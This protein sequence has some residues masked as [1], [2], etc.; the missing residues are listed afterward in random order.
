MVDAA[1]RRAGR[2]RPVHHAFRGVVVFQRPQHN[3]YVVLF[4]EFMPR[5]L[6]G[7]ELV[8]D[9]STVDKHGLGVLLT[10]VPQFNLKEPDRF[11][12]I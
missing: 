7:N 6:T 12:F 5:L 9:F 1:A 3:I 11:I 2:E 10:S 8:A 4:D